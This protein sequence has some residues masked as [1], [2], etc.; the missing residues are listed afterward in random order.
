MNSNDMRQDIIE[1]CLAM[2]RMGI[3]QGTSGNV[4]LRQGDGFLI[5]PSGMPYELMRPD[6]IVWMGF[7]GQLQ[8]GKPSSEWRFHLDILRNRPEICAIV[9]CHS[10]HATALACQMREIPPFHYMVAVAGGSS[11]RCAPYATF[12]TQ[13]LSDAALLAL[14]DRKACL[15]GHHGQIALGKDLRSA[16]NLAV[17]VETLAQTYLAACALGEPPLLP[18]EEIDRVLEQIRR[19][20]YGLSPNDLE[21]KGNDR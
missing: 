1:T 12:G 4:S 19:L 14:T 20:G 15:L 11:I 7:E 17:E 13:E 10:V 3:N 9:H 21:A 18:E 5:T 2:K 6:D 16:L 8:G